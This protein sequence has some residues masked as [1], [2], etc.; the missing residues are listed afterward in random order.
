ME[1]PGQRVLGRQLREG[2]FPRGEQRQDLRLGIGPQQ[3][4]QQLRRLRLPRLPREGERSRTGDARLRKL[5]FARVLLHGPAARAQA[6]MAVG[7]HALEPA[8]GGRVRADLREAGVQRRAAVAELAEQVIA[9]HRPAQRLARAA[10]AGDDEPV[11]KISCAVRGGQLVAAGL[12]P[13]AL[14]VKAADRLHARLLRSEAQHVEHAVGLVGQGIDPAGVLCYGQKPEPAEKFQ[15][16]LHAEARQGGLGKGG[17]LPVVAGGGGVVVGQVAPAVA[18]GQQLAA[19]PA[20]PLQ[21][22]DAAAVFRG[23]QRGHHA[24][25]AAA[26]DDHIRH[27]APSSF[28]R[29]R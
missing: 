9:C 19:H 28:R 20:L 15:R 16:V 21:Q 8:D 22:E 7:P 10:A 26:D 2:G 24:A 5:R 14:R 29:V 12:F 18:G 27:F 25:G 23:G 13:D 6:D 3:V 17:V 1:H 4:E 11:G